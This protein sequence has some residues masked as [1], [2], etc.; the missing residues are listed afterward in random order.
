MPLLLGLDECWIFNIDVAHDG[1]LLLPVAAAHDGF[2]IL[3]CIAR[4]H[5]SFVSCLIGL[6]VCVVVVQRFPQ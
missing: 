2:L 5:H 3:L 4:Y 1:F 6:S